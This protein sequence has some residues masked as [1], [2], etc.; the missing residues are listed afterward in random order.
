[1]LGAEN[2][3]GSMGSNASA[4]PTLNRFQWRVMISPL[5]KPVA[6]RSGLCSLPV[7]TMGNK[8]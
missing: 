1:M 5:Y 2:F 4:L 7:K 3:Y 8:P 6:V